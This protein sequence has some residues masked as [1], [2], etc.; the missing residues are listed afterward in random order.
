FSSVYFQ[1][2][3]IL[4][5]KNQ[6]VYRYLL[7]SCLSALPSTGFAH[8]PAASDGVPVLQADNRFYQ[9]WHIRLFDRY[10]CNF[11]VSRCEQTE[12]HSESGRLS[13]A[14]TA[15][16]TVHAAAWYFNIYIIYSCKFIKL[17]C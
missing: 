4:P 17:F 6:A 2:L 12:K 15:Q 13:C 11:S 16:K 8:R 3:Q 9:S 5:A 10:I 1:G 14:V 7:S